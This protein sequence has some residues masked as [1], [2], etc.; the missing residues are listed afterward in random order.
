MSGPP[1]CG[2]VDSRGVSPVVLRSVT[3]RARL[4]D[5]CASVQLEQHY[6]NETLETLEVTYVFPLPPAS[7]LCGFSATRHDGSVVE[8]VLKE[9]EQAK[10]MYKDAMDR[11]RTSF[12]LELNVHDSADL[13]RCSVGKL[14]S[15]AAVTVRL[16]YV[17]E[18]PLDGVDR[19][20]FVLPTAVAPRYAAL[21]P[22]TAVV[23][24]QAAPPEKLSVGAARLGFAAVVSM[25]SPIVSVAAHIGSVPL[26]SRAE[27]PGCGGSGE[28]KDPATDTY[29]VAGEELDLSEDLVIVVQQRHPFAPRMQVEVGD[30]D[31]KD[32]ASLRGSVQLTFCPERL[33]AS[34]SDGDDGDGGEDAQSAARGQE[35][36]ARAYPDFVFLVDRS[37]SMANHGAMTAARAALRILLRALP[38]GSSFNIAGFGDT[39]RKLWSSAVPYDAESLGAGLAHVDGMRADMGGTEM[40]GALDVVLAAPGAGTPRQ[41]VFLVTDGAVSG[42]ASLAARVR[43][44]AAANRVFTLGVGTGVSHDLVKS[45]AAAGCGTAEFATRSEDIAPALVRQLEQ[46]TEPLL[47]DVRID[48]TPLLGPARERGRV[49]AQQCPLVVPLLVPGTRHFVYALD[50]PVPRSV[51]S[52][53]ASDAPFVV[54]SG[55]YLVGGGGGGAGGGGHARRVVM[56]VA[57][58][59]VSVQPRSQSLVRL[60]GARAAINEIETASSGDA[61][62]THLSLRHGLLCR[63]TCFVAVDESRTVVGAD[64]R[65]MDLNEAGCPG[66][67]MESLH[68]VQLQSAPI[69]QTAIASS[70]LSRRLESCD[71]DGDDGG[72]VG[73][74]QS[75]R[76]GASRLGGWLSGR[77]NR[78]KPTS[79]S[80]GT[81]RRDASVDPRRPIRVDR[82]GGTNRCDSAVDRPTRVDRDGGANRRDSAVDRSTGTLGRGDGVRRSEASVTRLARRVDRASR[83]DR[84]HS[85]ADESTGSHGRAASGGSADRG[86]TVSELLIALQ[87][88][89]GSWVAGDHFDGVVA[90][91]CARC[92]GQDDKKRQHSTAEVCAQLALTVDADGRQ[93]LLDGVA[94][95]AATRGTRS[96]VLQGWRSSPPFE[97]VLSHVVGTAV[98]LALLKQRLPHERDLWSQNGIKGERFLFALTPPR[99]RSDAAGAGPTWQSLADAAVRGCGICEE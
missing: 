84:R 96:L 22:A 33:P 81:Y 11:N 48:W 18:V 60:L 7:A 15:G 10:E 23:V 46:A 87:T 25:P 44:G 63:N 75:L 39:C 20:R 21:S 9:A 52:F 31:G 47:A 95:A 3:A 76:S 4:S 91:C 98:A 16:R 40:G 99:R 50:V 88:H 65:A 89:T 53:A 80:E 55:R 54:V 72:R 67:Q 36:E 61:R 71:G 68:V 74:S 97:T 64:V 19:V 30:G 59:R 13:F 58:T 83:S 6:V 49:L 14:P 1:V 56:R 94:A 93:R 2:L 69:D 66:E 28:T 85:A 34:A 51:L 29:S 38:S 24:D 37:G 79:G 73:F 92:G 26:V 32:D 17:Q 5:F 8:A 62:A 90:G 43:R 86:P 27:P 82:D 45:L 12:L 77:L 41:V 57:L 35:T 70:A 78:L 42:V